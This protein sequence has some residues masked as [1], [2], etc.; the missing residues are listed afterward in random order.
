MS[1][2]APPGEPT[3]LL[4][5][6][7]EEPEPFQ[8]DKP[9]LKEELSRKENKEKYKWFYFALTEEGRT[10]F[11]KVWYAYMVEHRINLPLFTYMSIYSSE[12]GI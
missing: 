10:N 7:S 3:Q 4:V 8:I 12:N 11:K 1:D 6:M 5:I 2:M 9:F